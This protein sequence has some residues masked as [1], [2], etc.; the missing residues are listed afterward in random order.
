MLSGSLAACGGGGG[1]GILGADM[2][3]D[4]AS[5]I[6]VRADLPPPVYAPGDDPLPVGAAPAPPDPSIVIMRFA[7]RSVTLGVEPMAVWRPSIV[8]AE[9]PSDCKAGVAVLPTAHMPRIV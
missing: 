8:G 3:M 1:G 6:D 2:H 5:F 9:A 4:Q 7:A